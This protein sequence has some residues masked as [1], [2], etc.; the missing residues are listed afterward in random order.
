VESPMNRHLI[1]FFVLLVLTLSM[2]CAPKTP[3]GTVNKADPSSSVQPVKAGRMPA[4]PASLP[5]AGEQPGENQRPQER[6]KVEA[7]RKAEKPKEDLPNFHQ[8]HP[9]LYRG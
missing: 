6:S 2:D 9:Y 3:A 1:A 5:A 7:D 4:L 8:V